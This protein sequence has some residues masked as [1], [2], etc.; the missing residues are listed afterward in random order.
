[1]GCGVVNHREEAMLDFLANRI[2]LASFSGVVEASCGIVQIHDRG[3]WTNH[4]HKAWRF[5]S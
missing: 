5:L 2:E 1:M 4:G 3:Y